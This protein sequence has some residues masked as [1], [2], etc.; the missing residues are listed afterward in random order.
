MSYVPQLSKSF[1][2]FHIFCFRDVLKTQS[3]IWAGAFYE[4][5]S[6]INVVLWFCT[7]LPS[8]PLVLLWP[9]KLFTC[10]PTG[11]V[12]QRHFMST[13]VTTLL[14]SLRYL[15]LREKC[16]YSEVFWSVFSRIWTECG[17]VW[18]ISPYWVQVGE[19]TNQKNSKHGDFSLSIN[20]TILPRFTCSRSLSC[21]MEVCLSA[22]KN[23]LILLVLGTN[24]I[25]YNP[26]RRY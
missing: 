11:F 14:T 26:S 6:Q 17:E 10:N 3:N 4:N 20:F 16:L 22:Y 18:S 12:Y 23:Q 1:I 19:S 13:S 9:C 24:I 8:L 15:A 2:I 25:T 21:F 5:A 7:N